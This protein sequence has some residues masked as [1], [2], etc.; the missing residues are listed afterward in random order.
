M[1]GALKTATSVLVGVGAALGILR[2]T[3]EASAP[4]SSQIYEEYS[5][6]K[7]IALV[8]EV[9]DFDFPGMK[10]VFETPVTQMAEIPE[11]ARSECLVPIK[12]KSGAVF[13]GYAKDAQ[14]NETCQKYF[15]G[16]KFAESEEY[17][18]AFPQKLNVPD[19]YKD[20]V[21]TNLVR[22]TEQGSTCSLTSIAS[23]VSTL[24]INGGQPGIHPAVF[25]DLAQKGQ[26][27]DLKSDS[28]K[29]SEYSD[30]NIFYYDPKGLADLGVSVIESDLTKLVDDDAYKKLYEDFEILVKSNANPEFITSDKTYNDLAKGLF[31]H[32][33]T[34][35]ENGQLPNLASSVSKEYGHVV[36]VVGGKYDEKNGVYEIYVNEP[37]GGYTGWELTK[38]HWEKVGNNGLVKIVL[39][40]YNLALILPY[41]KNQYTFAKF[42]EKLLPPPEIKFEFAERS[43]KNWIKEDVKIKRQ[44]LPS[45]TLG[46]GA[47]STSQDKLLLFN[48]QKFLSG[49][50]PPPIVI[51]EKEVNTSQN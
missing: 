26:A 30:F 15:P 34:Q 46:F 33:M 45:E 16:V 25:S 35:L 41:L 22:F 20:Y 38:N 40:K 36:T 23:I 49:V 9:P 2:Q 42:D 11:E 37:T 12:N 6:Q 39:D 43:S 5:R 27:K 48:P 19:E 4:T 44:I 50:Q 18:G 7:S 32:L 3:V 29:L 17:L 24:R 10:F 8:E 28:R 1:K 14:D 51:G 21:K 47:I 31:N 13:W